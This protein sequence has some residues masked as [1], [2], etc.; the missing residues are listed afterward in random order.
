M[1]G[2]LLFLS[3]KQ[4]EA[5]SHFCL[6]RSSV[7]PS[8]LKSSIGKVLTPP[9][10]VLPIKSSI[11]MLSDVVSPFSL[12]AI[13]NWRKSAPTHLYLLRSSC[14][15]FFSSN[16]PDHG[17]SQMWSW[18]VWSLRKKP[19]VSFRGARYLIFSH[20]VSCCWSSMVV[21]NFPSDYVVNDIRSIVLIQND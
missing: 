2:R 8:L 6:L 12:V 5:I 10:S 17:L 4:E 3:D 15:G 14:L 7:P 18:P 19:R 11:R 13:R 20:Y 21:L 9:A 1:N 16:P